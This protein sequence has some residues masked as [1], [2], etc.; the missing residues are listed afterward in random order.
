MYKLVALDMDGTLLNE[1]KQVTE[2][3]KKAIKAARDK[4]VTVVLA[5]GRPI[6]GVT[7]YLEEL[8][9]LTES[10]YALTY[11][12][13][14][15]VKTKSRDVI[16]KIGLK[17]EDLH[18][19]HKLSKEFGVNIHAFSETEGLITPKD[20]KYTRVEADINNIK[21]KINDFSNIENDHSLIKVM[22]IDEPE[23]LQNAV[24]NLPN[25]VFEKYTV[26]RSTPYFL[27]FMNKKVNK[28][29]GLELLAKHLGVKQDEIISMGDAGNDLDMIEYAGM[30]IAM[31]NAFEEVKKAANYITDSNN[32][33]GVAKAIEKF[34]LE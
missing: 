25:E 19:L 6:D 32:E 7:R 5:T 33:D 8:E 10:D 11:N 12:G 21:F 29:T 27:E 2:R 23:L 28:G 17:G 1:N 31:A 34:I 24:D 14:L 3:T 9:M 26:V 4:G 22:M 20:S 16:S 30:G 15:V 18:Y 13:G